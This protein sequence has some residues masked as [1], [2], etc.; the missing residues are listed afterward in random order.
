MAFREFVRLDA[1]TTRA[2]CA[3]VALT[4][5]STGHVKRLSQKTLVTACQA[6]AASSASLG[7]RLRREWH[8]R[9]RLHVPQICSLAPRDCHLASADHVSRFLPARRLPARARG[10][11]SRPSWSAPIF[12][13]GL[14]AS[15][16]KPTAPACWSATVAR[17]ISRCHM[18]PGAN[19]GNA[20]AFRDACGNH[21]IKEP[22]Q[23]PSEL[24]LRLFRP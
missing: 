2:L 4:L 24:N 8:V 10:N 17:L 22:R 6:R 18:S 12:R 9:P 3:D 20:A 11:S 21:R 19:S 1:T 16:G 23:P 14:S 13:D 7:T 15:Q 5:S